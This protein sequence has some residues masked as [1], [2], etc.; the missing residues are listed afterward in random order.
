M[1]AVVCF[2]KICATHEDLLIS[3]RHNCERA[4]KAIRN[5]GLLE[6]V[7]MDNS[8][9]CVVPACKWIFVKQQRPV[10]QEFALSPSPHHQ[11]INATPNYWAH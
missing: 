5:A 9:T 7:L 3:V 10:L 6:I 2:E 1:L 8:R 11:H 4:K